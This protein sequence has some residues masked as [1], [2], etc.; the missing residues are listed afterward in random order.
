MATYKL[1]NAILKALNNKPMVE[2]NFCDLE[3]ACNYVSHHVI[4][5]K[6][7]TNTIFKPYLKDRYQRWITYNMDFNHNTYYN[8]G[9]IK[10]VF[11]EDQFCKLFT[12]FFI[13]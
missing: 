4:G 6:G 3:K 1:M 11:H 5:I 7:K 10:M 12:S 2:G 13:K 9:E 8:W